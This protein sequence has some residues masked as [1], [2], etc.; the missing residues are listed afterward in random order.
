[1][2][3]F[4]AVWW[5]E[6][7]LP[8]Y[9]HIPTKRVTLSFLPVHRSWK[10][11]RQLACY[12]WY[13]MNRNTEKLMHLI[14][15]YH[16]AYF[17]KCFRKIHLVTLMTK[18]VAHYPSQHYRSV[19]DAQS[20]KQLF[21]ACSCHILY[22]MLLQERKESLTPFKGAQDC[23][24]IRARLTLFACEWGFIIKKSE[25]NTGTIK[26]GDKVDG[27][28]YKNVNGTATNAFSPLSI[29]AQI[30]SLRHLLK[31]MRQCPEKE[32]KSILSGSFTPVLGAK[33]HHGWRN[34]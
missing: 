27:K 33:D 2:S 22:Y 34:F 6:F 3:I 24:M 14:D 28:E 4:G 16:A 25:T 26:P 1:M 23:T 21:I 19:V 29:I 7:H 18:A 17:A 15:C 12:V 11:I 30:P 13:G 10:F 31:R 8:V 20:W 5:N 9:Q 32:R